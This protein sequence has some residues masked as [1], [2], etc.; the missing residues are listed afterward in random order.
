ML[1]KSEMLNEI[2][3]FFETFSVV[4]LEAKID[5][6]DVEN[7]TWHKRE[8]NDVRNIYTWLFTKF[9]TIVSQTNKFYKLEIRVRANLEVTRSK[10]FV[11]H[12]KNLKAIKE[13]WDK[14]PCKESTF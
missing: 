5:Y 10:E 3:E 4:L 9:F 6:D 14:R 8:F 11:D 13:Q 2:W 7:Y 12:L 1:S